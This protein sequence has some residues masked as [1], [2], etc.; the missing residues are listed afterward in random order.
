MRRIKEKQ[1][2][3]TDQAEV[4]AKQTLQF[5][6]LPWLLFPKTFLLALQEVLHTST[7]VKFSSP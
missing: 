5:G 3:P 4:L 2:Q 1:M 6:F 7:Y